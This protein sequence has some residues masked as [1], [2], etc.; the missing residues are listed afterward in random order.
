MKIRN[1]STNT[2]PCAFHLNGGFEN[3]KYGHSIYAQFKKEYC[4][5][6]KEKLREDVALGF[7]ML[8]N[9]EKTMIEE[10]AELFGVSVNNI[11]CTSLGVPPKKPGSAFAR[12]RLLKSKPFAMEKFLLNNPSLKYVIGW[13]SSDVFLAKHPNRIV[14]IFESD[15][16]CKILFNAE[17]SLY[18]SNT[19]SIY[20]KLFLKSNFNTTKSKFCY[21]NS[22]LFIA[23]V[24]YYLS[25]M[26]QYR[27]IDKRNIKGND[28]ERF[29]I[30]FGENHGDI[31]IDFGCKIFQST[32]T[33]NDV[34]LTHESILNNNFDAKV[35][36][37]CGGAINANRTFTTI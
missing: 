20:D 8:G 13:D 5:I 35:I 15:F 33:M 34:E 6:E 16:D 11:Y 9:K 26:K 22:G 21:L 18:P 14:E 17:K 37:E 4:N 36:A 24:E 10:S 1:T 28:Q 2:E 7:Y 32:R 31:Q 25:M 19:K 30:L 23:D 29:Q 12:R 27:E 3:N